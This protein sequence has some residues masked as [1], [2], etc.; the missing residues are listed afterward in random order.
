MRSALKIGLMEAKIPEMLDGPTL[1]H[2]WQLVRHDICMTTH[3]GTLAT[4]GYLHP[5]PPSS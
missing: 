4:C 3:P 1:A 2:L 5:T